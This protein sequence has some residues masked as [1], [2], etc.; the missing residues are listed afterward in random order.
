MTA[1]L[2]IAAEQ[3]GIDQSN[4]NIRGPQRIDLDVF[5]QRGPQQAGRVDKQCIDVDVARLR[6]LAARERKQIRGEVGATGGGFGDQPCDC[7][8]V[9]PIRNR[10]RQDFDRSADDGEDVVEVVHDAASQLTDDLHPSGLTNFRFRG[11]HR[12]RFLKHILAF[13]PRRRPLLH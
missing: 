4:R 1:R 11:F 6:W 10:F 9:R 3:I 13:P 7:G 8:K 12:Q 5:A 2:R